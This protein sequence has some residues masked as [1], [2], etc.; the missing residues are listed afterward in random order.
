[1]KTTSNSKIFATLTITLLLIS[2][3]F[4]ATPLTSAMVP[5]QVTPMDDTATATT[6]YGITL[7]TVHPGVIAFI[8]MDFPAGFDLSAADVSAVVNLG[9]GY[10]YNF[11]NQT[12]I[13][14]VYSPTFVPADKI[15]AIEI[16]NIVNIN[17]SGT[18]DVGLTTLQYGANDEIVVIDGPWHSE[19][20]FINP[21]L[22][23]TPDYGLSGT[24]VELTGS[25]FIPNDIVNLLFNGTSFG[26]VTADASGSF[27]TTYTI[28]TPTDGEWS[29]VYFNA[30]DASDFYAEAL[31]SLYGP[32]I[33]RSQS[34]G[35]AG[36][37]VLLRGYDFAPNSNVTIT[38]DDAAI[39]NWT[40]TDADGQF[41][42]LTYTVPND[43]LDRH[44]VT[45]TDASGN[46][47][48]TYF[49]I[50]APVIDFWDY[51]GVS[52]ST[53]TLYG[54][55][56]T[57]N[58]EVSLIWDENGTNTN[59]GTTTTQMNGRFETT[60]TIPTVTPGLYNVSA[61]DANLKSAYETFE[62]VPSKIMLNSTYDYVGANVNIT[63]EGFAANSAVAI[64]WNGT[65]FAST[66]TDATGF[67]SRTITIPHAP[68]GDY[69]I[70]ATDAASNTANE[71]FY[72]SED[73]TLSVTNGTAGSR[74]TAIGTGW[75]A[76]TNF[77]IYFDYYSLT[78]TVSS[79]TDEKGDFNVTFTVPALAKGVYY[80][81]VSYD[82]RTYYGSDFEILPAITLSPS[83]GLVTTVVGTSFEPNSAVTIL[84]ND[85]TVPTVPNTIT[86]DEN[87]NFTAI[88]SFSSTKATYIITAI[89]EY[90]NTASATFR[91]PD[92]TGATG[93]TGATGQ[94]GSTGAT[95]ATG[96][97]G[98]TGEKGD[99]GAT[100]PTASPSPADTSGSTNSSL[101]P[102]AIGVVALILA[103]VAILAVVLR[104]K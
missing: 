19:D 64:T 69:T 92:Y 87:G 20:F 16:S 78:P 15:V 90:N 81:V 21:L 12:L 100:G 24:E 25:Y 54:A 18:Y 45:V 52:G 3:V 35:S 4:A 41:E 46:I 40:L 50:R 23:V 98:E 7:T 27:T 62:V 60:F 102:L 34:S 47:A 6:D 82:D 28:N 65:T 95:G 53:M 94:T 1:M 101:V 36:T 32:E 38:W 17:A 31:F 5:L 14:S 2:M 48:R 67:F 11:D 39:L 51:S 59:L 33:E 22:T 83:S 58:S 29:D 77:A 44:N 8:Q 61:I 85:T 42:N 70:A 43:T 66:T 89:D 57:P 84:S 63:G 13:Y 80:L 37:I 93:A 76:S 104:R 97:K 91:V 56:F 79:T 75:K 10:I 49:R 68:G 9:D 73:M 55:Y 99:T 86:T 30:T 72:L 74:V 26:S 96:E 103:V 88:I 71:M